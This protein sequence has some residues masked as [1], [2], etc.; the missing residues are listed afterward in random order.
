MKRLLLMRHAEAG[1]G[2]GTDHAR[3]LTDHGR[4]QASNAGLW[5]R[6]QGW[7]IDAVVASD[8]VRTLQT[9]EHVIESFAALSAAGLS[10]QAV[11]RLYNAPMSMYFETICE[12]AAD[13]ESVLVVGHNPAVAD[14]MARAAGRPVSVVTA[15][16]ADIQLSSWCALADTGT[17][18]AIYLPGGRNALELG[19]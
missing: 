1:H 5:M 12:F 13:W 16:T 9:A 7:R 17:A 6:D 2:G 19:R 3:S 14:V 10:V 4:Q 15:T 18:S 8:A 11:P